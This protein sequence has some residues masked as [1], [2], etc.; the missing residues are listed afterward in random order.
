M[1][2]M[3]TSPAGPDDR[4]EVPAPGVDA[5]APLDR[6]DSGGGSEPDRG[7]VPSDAERTGTAEDEADA[8]RR[9]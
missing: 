1:E 7:A 9:R 2:D 6:D 3:T 8:E 4:P 5:V